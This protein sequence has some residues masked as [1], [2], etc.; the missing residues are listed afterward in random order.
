LKKQ[1]ITILTGTG[2]CISPSWQQVRLADSRK[3]LLVVTSF[4]DSAHHVPSSSAVFLFEIDVSTASF[5][6]LRKRDTAGTDYPTKI[7]SAPQS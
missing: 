4:L 1:N 2:R 7:R 3:T 5:S 6:C